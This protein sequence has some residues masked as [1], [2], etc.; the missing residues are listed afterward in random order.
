MLQHDHQQPAVS[1]LESFIDS[2]QND[3]NNRVESTTASSSHSQSDAAVQTSV[4]IQTRKLKIIVQRE[5]TLKQTRKLNSF[6]IVH[7]H[8][9]D[10]VDSLIQELDDLCSHLDTPDLEEIIN[11]YCFEDDKLSQDDWIENVE[12]TSTIA[13]MTPEIIHNHYCIMSPTPAPEPILHASNNNNTPI[14][15]SILKTHRSTWITRHRRHQA[16][17]EACHRQEW[18]RENRAS[19]CSIEGPYVFARRYLDMRRTSVVLARWVGYMGTVAINNK[20]QAST[21]CSK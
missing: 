3:S 20:E 15:P 8:S 5:G 4:G 1:L 6:S 16:H 12:Q 13:T 18:V 17:L 7:T 19:I 14:Q 9:Q 2:L 10:M 21:C 11:L